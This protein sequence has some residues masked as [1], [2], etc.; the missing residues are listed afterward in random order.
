L[1]DHHGQKGDGNLLAARPH[2]N[3]F[4][5]LLFGSFAF[6]DP[7]APPAPPPMTCNDSADCPAVDVCSGGVCAV[8]GRRCRSAAYSSVDCPANWTCLDNVCVPM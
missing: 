3:V 1:D 5:D 8:G 2:A 6:Q 7:D 4:Q